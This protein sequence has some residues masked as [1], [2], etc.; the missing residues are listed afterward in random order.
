MLYSFTP[1][2]L[3]A[4]TGNGHEF[5]VAQ[6]CSMISGAHSAMRSLKKQIVCIYIYV[7]KEYN[8]YIYMYYFT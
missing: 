5:M 1:E 4:E 2:T 7:Y 3:L 8:I 6:I